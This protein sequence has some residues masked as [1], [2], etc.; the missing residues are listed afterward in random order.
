MIRGI[1]ETQQLALYSIGERLK[2]GIRQG[3]QRIKCLGINLMIGERFVYWKL[4]NFAEEIKDTKMERHLCSSIG[5]LY[6]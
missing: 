3:F 4:E 5:K 2:S 6:C 1:Y